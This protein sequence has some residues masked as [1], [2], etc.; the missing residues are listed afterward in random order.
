MYL[1]L[2]LVALIF[3]GPA[4]LVYQQQIY[5]FIDGTI[6][7]LPLYWQLVIG[8]LVFLGIALLFAT[9]VSK[10]FQKDYDRW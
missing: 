6:G 3:I 10:A 9:V 1:V 8:G 5:H 4:V 7:Q 2:L